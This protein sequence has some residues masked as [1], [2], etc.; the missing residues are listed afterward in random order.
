MTIPPGLIHMLRHAFAAVRTLRIAY[1]H[2]TL[3]DEDFAVA[4]GEMSNLDLL[5]LTKCRPDAGF[6]HTLAQPSKCPALGTL[7]FRDALI[8]ND[9]VSTPL[10]NFIRDR[11]DA[12]DRVARIQHLEA[13]ALVDP[14]S[15]AV[16][17]A[18]AL[19]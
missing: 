16:Q 7:K 5:D 1:E 3:I 11:R 6:F 19:A 18:S 12:A 2:E 14:G 13:V 4:L 17:L 9:G 15:F 8:P 10:L